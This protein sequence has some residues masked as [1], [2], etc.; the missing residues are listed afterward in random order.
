MALI[1]ALCQPFDFIFADEPVSH[2]D[3]TNSNIMAEIL[4][5]EARRQGAAVIVTSIGKRL[6][7]D[8]DK[9]LKL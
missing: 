5:N 6:N 9:V 1:R 8:Y 3:D 2:L 7:I 4:L